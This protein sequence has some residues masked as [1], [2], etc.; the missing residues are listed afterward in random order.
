MQLR[1]LNQ[2]VEKK[3]ER[4]YIID[5]SAP[6]IIYHKDMEN[7]LLRVNKAFCEASGFSR[8][9]IEGKS[10]FDISP[11]R[12]VARRN[13]D[14]DLE[15]VRSGQP[16]RNI[17]EPFWMDPNR[18]C[19]TDKIPSIDSGGNIVGVI[20]FSLEVTELVQ[21]ERELKSNLVHASAGGREL[22]SLHGLL[23]VFQ[24]KDTPDSRI[25]KKIVNLIPS[26]FGNSGK[27]GARLSILG[28]THVSGH[29]TESMERVRLDIPL[30]GERT[31]T[32]EIGAESRP[33]SPGGT[34]SRIE[35]SRLLPLI[36]NVISGV[37]HDRMHAEKA[38]EHDKVFRA[39]ADLVPQGVAII[40]DQ[41]FH[42]ADDTFAAMFGF[43]G[44]TY[45][46]GKN[47]DFLE[48]SGFEQALERMIASL[49]SAT[50]QD[51]V[52]GSSFKDARGRDFWAELQYHGITVQGAPALILSMTD[53]SQEKTAQVEIEKE[54]EWL[55]KENIK[56]RSSMKDRYRFGDI[57]GRSMPMQE[58]YDLILRATASDA[59]VVI[60][61][62]SGTGKELIAST[63]HK[64]SDRSQKPFVPVNC[65]AI[66]EPLFESEFFGH[67]KG[68]FTGAH[69]D[70][71]GFFD[72]GH[73]GTLFLDEIGE[74]SMNMQVKLLRAIEGR[75]YTPVGDTKVRISDV[76]IIAATN[77][78]LAH[79]VKQGGMR[80]DFFYRIHI[81]PITLPPLKNRK[82]DIPLLVDHF[83]QNHG[84]GRKITSIPGK[85]LDALL[86]Y[87]WPGN[88]REL[89]NVLH[90]YLTVDRLDFTGAT[91]FRSESRAPERPAADI[92]LE[93]NL[94]DALDAYEKR[95]ITDVLD[96]NRW[97]RGKTAEV[98]QIPPRTL[99]RKMKK[100]NLI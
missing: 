86:N 79:M 8:I 24:E 7:R 43:E 81:I 73:E 82:E 98:L 47:V 75:G 83:L 28:E 16:K 1:G 40:T 60:Y 90:R 65:G 44:G 21:A 74:L 77:R 6:V 18:W 19:R 100:Y 39:L 54:R 23:A 62:E 10:L 11:D 93:T 36:S 71:H 51:I 67:K 9:E 13:W 80:E 85:V 68:S 56:L 34:S 78:N 66:P 55:L 58:V 52:F 63:I 3:T 12:T 46:E 91:E 45:I 25:Y 30:D 84:D 20:G 35:E 41:T 29:F 2:M 59:N 22:S 61:G 17:I 37:A 99:Y 26:L 50:Q 32:L 5:D 31:G 33:G 72:L 27:V 57:V 94:R 38:G 87:D 14:D 70:K 95:Y 96:K 42:F 64:L 4:F 69:V 76:R 92:S 15:V 48:G 89:Q 49:D 88:V 97:H 53:V